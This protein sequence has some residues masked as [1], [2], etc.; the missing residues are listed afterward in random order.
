[1]LDASFLAPFS[2]NQHRGYICITD[3]I[4]RRMRR[5]YLIN[6]L[7]STKHIGDSHQLF[8]FVMGE[9]DVEEFFII[10]D[11][12]ILWVKDQ[13]ETFLVGSQ[14]WNMQN[15]EFSGQFSGVAFYGP[16]SIAWLSN[17]TVLVANQYDSN[18]KMVDL[19]D[20]FNLSM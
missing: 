8:D 19:R 2:L 4:A 7:I 10:T 9:K 13:Q 1:M 12:G 16:R 15:I 17:T 18:V 3:R 11:H 5:F 14:Q 20:I 6:E